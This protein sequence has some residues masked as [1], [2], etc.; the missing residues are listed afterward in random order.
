M[1]VFS[2]VIQT[3][4]DVEKLQELVHTVSCFESDTL[5][6]IKGRIV[7]MKS[8][9]GLCTVMPYSGDEIEVRTSGYDEEEAMLAIKRWFCL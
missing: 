8:I 9:L 1:R 5:L 6:S 4:L 2:F 3:E 7:D